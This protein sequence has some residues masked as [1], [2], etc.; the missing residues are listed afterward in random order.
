[1]LELMAVD[2]KAR[3]GAMHLV[4]MKQ[5][6]EAFVTNQFDPEKLRATLEHFSSATESR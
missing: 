3:D 1:M 5:L 2:K 4:L 6:G